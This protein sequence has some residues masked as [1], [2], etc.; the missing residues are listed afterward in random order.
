MPMSKTPSE[1]RYRELFARRRA[2]EALV[3]LATGLRVKP[4]MFYYWHQ[5]LA[6]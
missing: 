6:K 2:G 3:A 5:K 1:V 4:R